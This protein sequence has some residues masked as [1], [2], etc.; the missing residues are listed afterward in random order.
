MVTQ[1]LA[2]NF[3][4]LFVEQVDSLIDSSTDNIPIAQSHNCQPLSFFFS[5]PLS[6]FGLLEV[7]SLQQI[8]FSLSISLDLLL[9]W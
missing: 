3:V 5:K 2:A 1:W 9:L 6:D 8:N 4:E 7:N